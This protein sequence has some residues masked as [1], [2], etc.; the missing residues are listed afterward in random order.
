[1]RTLTQAVIKPDGNHEILA[2]HLLCGDAGCEESLEQRLHPERFL[3][4]AEKPPR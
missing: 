4:R 2:E 1:M 3:E